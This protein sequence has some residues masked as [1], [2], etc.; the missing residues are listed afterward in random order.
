MTLWKHPRLHVQIL[1]DSFFK[2][3]QQWL[4]ASVQDRVDNGLSASNSSMLQ[5]DS[6]RRQTSQISDS[7]SHHLAVELA[8]WKSRVRKQ[9]QEL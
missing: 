4:S 9:R 3:F 5:G 7:D 8:D 2:I 6:P 1:Q